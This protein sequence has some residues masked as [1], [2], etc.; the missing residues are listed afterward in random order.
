VQWQASAAPVPVNLMDGETII[1]PAISTSR[2]VNDGVP[3]PVHQARQGYQGQHG[4][5]VHQQHQGHNGHA[6]SM[7]GLRGAPSYYVGAPGNG[8]Q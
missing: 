2:K 8:Y 7:G 6:Q 5:Q 4:Y 1:M 3:V